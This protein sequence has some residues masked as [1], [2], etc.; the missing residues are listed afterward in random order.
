MWPL[1]ADDI[2]LHIKARV[3]FVPLLKDWS[4]PVVFEPKAEAKR[5]KNILDA[6][7]YYVKMHMIKSLQSASGLL[8]LWGQ[9]LRWAANK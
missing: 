9:Q 2:I 1:A 7:A 8:A 3:V 4:D 6:K 5:G